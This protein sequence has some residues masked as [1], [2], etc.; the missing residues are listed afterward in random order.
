MYY[1]TNITD[2]NSIFE[3]VG[4]IFKSNDI[5]SFEKEIQPKEIDT[6]ESVKIK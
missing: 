2:T 4:V 3:F 5:L 6:K 1:V